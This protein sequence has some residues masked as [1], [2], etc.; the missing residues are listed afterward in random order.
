MG[1]AYTYEIYVRDTDTA[2]PKLFLRLT[3]LSGVDL[4]ILGIEPKR[5]KT[6]YARD[7]GI[8]KPISKIKFKSWWRKG[9]KLFKIFKQ[10]CEIFKS[11]LGWARCLSRV[12]YATKYFTH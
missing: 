8:G 7:F 2:R 1:T 9:V 6:H 10:Q 4:R 3:Y 12:W 11:F 5:L